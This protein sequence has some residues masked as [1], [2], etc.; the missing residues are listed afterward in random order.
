L[1]RFAST[2]PSRAEVVTSGS[3]PS[4]DTAARPV[5]SGFTAKGVPTVNFGFGDSSGP[6]SAADT[7]KTGKDVA[8]ETTFDDGAVNY[9]GSTS[10]AV[11]NSLPG[12]ASHGPVD[13]SS[14]ATP[15]ASTL[16]SGSSS[17]EVVPLPA[18]AA[19]PAAETAKPKQ[20]GTPVP[21]EKKGGARRATKRRGG[22]GKR[23]TEQLAS[24][25]LPVDDD[26]GSFVEETPVSSLC[27]SFTEQAVVQDSQDAEE[28]ESVDDTD[29]FTGELEA[30]PS[31]AE[32]QAQALFREATAEVVEVAAE[33]E[34]H[35]PQDGWSL[36]MASETP[37]EA[38]EE[39]GVP[40]EDDVAVQNSPSEVG[41]EGYSW[42]TVGEA[43]ANETE[44]ATLHS[45]QPA[46]LFP[47]N[48]AL[49]EAIL[50]AEFFAEWEAMLAAFE[51]EP[52][53][54]TADVEAVVNDARSQY[55]DTDVLPVPRFS[56]VIQHGPSD[57]F[58]A[59]ST[60]V[61]DSY[62]RVTKTATFTP[63]FPLSTTL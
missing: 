57:H 13:A 61:G 38:V 51:K 27:S 21:V 32:T 44:E 29:L 14:A 59:L 45:Q 2:V 40:T 35:H 1:K 10:S 17:R 9:G 19:E 55:E 48:M 25:A 3:N 34:D 15:V 63:G 11:D 62:N 43:L 54:A 12:A 33:E 18:D 5:C 6:A 30:T 39:V 46:A 20:K 60:I 53:T 23:K 56:V 58:V 28:E 41:P 22:A 52:S 36:W 4:T 31:I 8:F 24:K 26:A 42:R 16:E 47:E 7:I 37:A 49:E 50:D